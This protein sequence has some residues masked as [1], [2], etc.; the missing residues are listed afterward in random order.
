M[1]SPFNPLTIPLH[2]TH[3]IEAS[4]GTGKTYT[5]TT[6]FLRLILEQKLQINQILVV[7]FTEAATE[8]LRDRI[9]RR[10]R[11]TLNFIPNLT[12]PEQLPLISSNPQIAHP[13]STDPELLELLSLIL[14]NPQTAHEQLTLALRE[15]NEA[16]IF[17]IHSF[18]QRMLQDHAFET[19]LL[20]DIDLIQN[21]FPLLKEIVED[22]WR[23]QLYPKTI[24]LFLNYLLENH[25]TPH[26][27]LQHLNLERCIGQPFLK[28]IPNYTQDLQSEIGSQLQTHWTKLQTAWQDHHL[29]VK[30]LLENHPSLNRNK[31]GKKYVPT[32]CQTLDQ[33][34]AKDQPHFGKKVDA[35]E[36][37]QKFTQS[38]IQ[39]AT[40]KGTISPQHPFFNQF[41]IFFQQ[42]KQLELHLEQQLIAFKKQLI[43]TVEEK[44][45]H[46]KHLLRV[47]SFQ[48]LLVNLYQTLNH[49]ITGPTLAAQIRERYPAALIDEFQDTD[50]VQYQIFKTI[51]GEKDTHILFL[52]GDPKQ[53]IYSFRGADV[54]TYIQAYQDVNL[55]QTLSTNWRSQ[56]D[57]ISAVNT[58]FA[59]PSQHNRP[60]FLLENIQFIPI[61]PPPNSKLLPFFLPSLDSSPLQLWFAER[62]Q[63]SEDQEQL[64]Q[65][66][67]KQAAHRLIPQTVAREILQ[68]LNL[69][70]SGQAY[71]LEDEQK[72]PLTAGDIAILVRS[73]RQAAWMQKALGQLSIPSVLHTQ[74]SLLVSREV[75][76]VRQVLLGILYPMH[77]PKV[78][79]AL[80]TEL[81][82]FSG[83][84]LHELLSQRA[85][86]QQRCY[87]FWE[88]HED[89]RNRGFIQ[90]FQKLLMQE[91]VPK[92]LLSYP[93]GERRLTNVL[94]I[95]EVLQQAVVQEQLGMNG[96]YQWLIGQHDL[97]NQNLEI[98]PLRL[99]SDEK[100]VKI[101]T[102]HKSKGLEYP[103]VFC[104]FLWDGHLH[105]GGG[106]DS[107]QVIFHD[108]N[109]QLILDLGSEQQKE[110]RQQA[111]A[112]EQAEN[113]RLCYV[114]LTRA[115]HRCY[116]IWGRF[117]EAEKSALATLLHPHRPGLKEEDGVLKADIEALASQ[118]G[119][120][121]K[122]CTFPMEAKHENGILSIK[123]VQLQARSFQG[124]I[125]KTWRVTSF[126][127]LTSNLQEGEQPDYDA[128]SWWERDFLERPD[129]IFSFPRG[130]RAGHFM[131]NL[132]E[133]LDF[134]QSV[135]EENRL[136]SQWLGNFGYD[137]K[138]WSTVIAGM[139]DDV[140]NTPLEAGQVQFTL[141]AI[142]GEQRLNE[143]EFYYPL[144]NP[145]TPSGLWG[146]LRRFEEFSARWMRGKR[147]E[148][149]PTR[150]M[151]KGF[152]DLVFEYQGRYYMVDYKS[153]F[154]GYQMENYYRLSLEGVMAEE[155]YFLQYLVYMV[156][157]HRYLEVHLPN[158]QY[159]QHI[160]GV[161]YLF[162]RGMRP[163]WGSHY[164][165]FKEVPP[166]DLIRELSVYF[167]GEKRG[168]G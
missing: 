26:H 89:W 32:W 71:F 46:K 112:E 80:S 164:G 73:H 68:L 61:N 22:F 43:A 52:I 109:Q 146:I 160:G 143:W 131:H 99:E 23:Q 116:V 141:S 45:I 66:I 122:V 44:L 76:E 39:A 60:P 133:H 98:Q 64:E 50:P 25:P 77:E 41:E 166:G 95:A 92:R 93:D 147:V 74:E 87:H 104:P 53:A 111:M 162:L 1:T 79:A 120:G 154:L 15:F 38:A 57:L 115:R 96:L 54:F 17:T 20:F 51:Y 140:L 121:I 65:P 144:V 59:H 163:Y 75:D 156:A 123:S 78:K 55:R 30:D 72:I 62:K 9:R 106:Q 142:G 49:P 33:F 157:L 34:L 139:V 31:Y 27:L 47:H 101:V 48:D 97:E 102:V 6:L 124:L 149:L 14:P 11:K 167:A 155:T 136:I 165:V 145:V 40:K 132:F 5:I 114:A 16:A 67:L 58:L 153:N 4:A 148:F 107:H 13:N 126:T 90:M 37:L 56:P 130:S 21:Q 83:E 127:G 103:V 129:D 29:E 18:C 100:L 10:L 63:F 94:H 70:E 88:Y 161:F 91:Q 81:L 19:G 159:E 3:L 8:E 135:K 152:V 84:A 85:A 108:D 24:S 113:I 134:T 128:V 42:Y 86:W 2:G 12:D 168:L 125:D 150:G 110:H 28:I 82:G 7:T 151:M 137:V 69:A 119:G 118:S 138:R 36:K 35:N 105:T 158:Y 117:K